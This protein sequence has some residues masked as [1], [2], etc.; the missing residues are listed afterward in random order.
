[1]RLINIIALLVAINVFIARSDLSQHCNPGIAFGI[2]L[3][4]AFFYLMWG[5]VMCFVL[6]LILSEWQKSRMW[7]RYGLYLIFIGGVANMADRMIHGCVIDY[8][9]LVPWNSFN[10]ADTAICIGA[11]IVIFAP[12]LQSKRLDCK[13][14]S[15]A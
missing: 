11:A 10:I 9:T 12:H 5:G 6:I 1:M 2:E 8:I 7:K 15:G 4:Q 3:P 13:G 14:K